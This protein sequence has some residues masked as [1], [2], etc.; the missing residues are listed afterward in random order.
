MSYISRDTKLDHSGD[1]HVVIDYEWTLDTNAFAVGDVMSP[2][3][4]LPNA[5]AVAGGTGSVVYLQLYEKA[6][7]GA[8]QHPTTNFA[9]FKKSFTPA[10]INA[11]MTYTGPL[12]DIALHEDMNNTFY[13]L[14]TG[15]ATTHE[16]MLG[17]PF[18]AAAT[19]TSLWVILICGAA[20]T[21]TAN[22]KML[23]RVCIKRD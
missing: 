13:D 18:Q 15:T 19:E 10:A 21:F 7:S 17:F 9:F 6:G 23:L 12:A 20:V 4:E 11:A 16:F 8:A 14:V 1:D 5:V 22:S 2:L 3:I